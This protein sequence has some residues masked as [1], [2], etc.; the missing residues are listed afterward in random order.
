[1]IATKRLQAVLSVR[2]LICNI[3]R[4]WKIIN[5]STAVSG[6]MMPL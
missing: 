3:A 4:P 6:K 2:Q 1:M 5:A